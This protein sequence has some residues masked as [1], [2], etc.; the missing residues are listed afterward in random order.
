MSLSDL[1]QSFDQQQAQGGAQDGA[2]LVDP[3]A[4]S[5]E[6]TGAFSFATV[7]GSFKSWGSSLAKG[8]EET[9]Y[10]KGTPLERTFVDVE[11]GAVEPG[12]A[13]AAP[14]AVVDPEASVNALSRSERFK[15]FVLLLALSGF[16]FTLALVFLGTVII[17][18]AK[19]AFPFSMGS[20][21]FMASFALIKGPTAWA[22][23]VCSLAQLPFTVAYFASILGTLYACLV[24]RSYIF[25]MIFSGVQL[26]AL[27]YYA[28]GN[29]PGGKYGLRLAASF[30][31][32]V[33]ETFAG[34][35]Q[36]VLSPLAD[37]CFLDTWT[38]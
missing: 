24:W 12:A 27:G 7:Q 29:M 23:S 18:P 34:L 33:V 20:I 1:V 8:I 28:F 37:R 25:T 38:L 14:V 5:G 22:K 3:A 32:Q 11:A 16:F 30:L 36:K 19:F 9:G 2:L 26:C 6:A 35:A 13:G 17:F 31:R 10:L 4:S 21:F 15:G